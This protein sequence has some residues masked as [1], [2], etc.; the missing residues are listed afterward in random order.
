MIMRIYRLMRSSNL[1]PLQA[2]CFFSP[3]KAIS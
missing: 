2:A 1:I 3:A